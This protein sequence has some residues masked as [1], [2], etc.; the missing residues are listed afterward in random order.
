M[1]RWT[2]CS[3]MARIEADLNKRSAM[4]QEA[5]AIL[6][7]ELPV[8]PIFNYV[9]TSLKQRYIKGFYANKLDQHPLRFVKFD[10]KLRNKLFD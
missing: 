6:M 3:A 9:S 4:L 7:N 2:T 5:E 8:L 1:A 10:Q